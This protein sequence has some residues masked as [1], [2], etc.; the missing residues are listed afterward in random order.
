MIMFDK[1]ADLTQAQLLVNDIVQILGE[2]EIGDRAFMMG[3]VRE[4]TFVSGNRLIPITQGLKVEIM[5]ELVIT[6]GEASES[7][8]LTE[9]STT[10]R[11]LKNRFGAVV[12]VLDFGAMGDGIVD[13]TKAFQ[14]SIDAS[15]G[16]R[17]IYV[18]YGKYK[19]T[20]KL[21]IMTGVAFEFA[22][23]VLL[24]CSANGMVFNYKGGSTN[25]IGGYEQ[26]HNIS[27]TCPTGRTYVNLNGSGGAEG[28][29]RGFWS[30][31]HS[32]DIV[33]SNISFI[34][35][36]RAHILEFNSCKNVLVDNCHFLGNE[37]M[38]YGSIYGYEA[39]QIDYSSKTGAPSGP[40]WDD[41][42]CE[43]VVVRNCVF[44]DCESAVGSHAVNTDRSK[45]HTGIQFVGNFIYNCV[46]PIK[47]SFL[48]SS[49]VKDNVIRSPFQRGIL[50]DS[51]TDLV[52]SN[53]IVE[54]HAPADWVQPSF[55]NGNTTGIITNNYVPNAFFNRN[56]SITDNTIFCKSDALS[57]TNR[58]NNGMFLKN[59]EDMLVSGNTIRNAYSGAIYLELD[60]TDVTVSNNSAYGCANGTSHCW[61]YND[62]SDNGGTVTWS[63]NYS[64]G[65]GSTNANGRVFDIR[66]NGQRVRLVGNT[67]KDNVPRSKFYTTNTTN[68]KGL[69]INDMEFIWTNND[70]NP[71]TVGSVI[72]LPRSVTMYTSLY[73]MGGAVSGDG[74]ITGE[75]FPFDRIGGFRISDYAQIVDVNGGRYRVEVISDTTL[76]IKSIGSNHLRQVQG[77]RA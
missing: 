10:R 27:F 28:A 2:N 47:C 17:T 41:T 56:I 4:G 32:Q 48:D 30:P 66:V 31:T 35:G 24:D 8:V 1:I 63:S 77:K 44:H 3:M 16:K 29:Y 19:I 72:Q 40:P 18:P 51:C 42:P 14:D 38:D 76:E 34:K 74:F 55:W 12:N 65:V 11:N 64:D 45:P 75:C 69:S 71:G 6:S 23:N 39:I 53:N 50:I 21:E 52:V 67:Y 46:R 70:S 49:I 33:V 9:G 7:L 73:L 43:N 57:A 26:A 62:T 36:N 22:N 60:L 68:Q 59:T 5:P 13:D 20:N 61:V 15:D 58:L 54:W 37:P 25:T